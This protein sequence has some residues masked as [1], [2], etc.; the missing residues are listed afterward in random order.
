MRAVGAVVALPLRIVDA[1]LGVPSSS[2]PSPVVRELERLAALRAAGQLT[3]EEYR[4]A[5][6]QLLG[7]ASS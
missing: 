1:V 6:E 5:K 4:R 7:G 2:G 3:P